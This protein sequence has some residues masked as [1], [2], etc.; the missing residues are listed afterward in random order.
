MITFGSDCRQG[1]QECV[2]VHACKSPCHQKAV[3]YK[4]SLDK[5]HPNY[6]WLEDEFNLYLNIID[7]LVPLFKIDSFIKFLEFASKHENVFIHCNQGQSRSPSLVMLLMAARG[8]IQNE[9]YWLA[10]DDFPHEPSLGIQVFLSEH[11]D[12]LIG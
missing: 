11:W 8:E 5:N 4:G 3:G 2:V 12:E 1:T 9:S 6:L 7:P 10:R